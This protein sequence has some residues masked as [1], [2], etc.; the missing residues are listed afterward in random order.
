MPNPKNAIIAVTFRC[1]ARCT[2][3]DIWKHGPTDQLK[4]EYY[5][6]LPG[7]LREVNITGGEPLL[8]NDL[9]EIITNL[10]LINPKMRIVLSTNGLLPE[11]LSRLLEDHRD[12]V[13]RVS[14]DAIGEKHDIIRGVE[15]AYQKA[16]LSVEVAKKHGIKDIGICTTITRENADEAHKVQL[17]A[18]ALGVSFTA[19]VVHSSP[20][21]FGDQS[22]CKPDPLQT[23]DTLTKISNRFYASA[24]VK[25]WFKGY[26]V[27]G[28][29][30]LARGAPR[31]I[32]CHAGE[33]FFYLDPEGNIFP[34]HLWEKSIG[35][36]IEETYEEI[37]ARNPD[38]RQLVKRCPQKCW[39]TCTVAPEIRRSPLK[40]LLHVIGKKIRTMCVKTNED[41]AS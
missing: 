33:E 35:N 27:D 41:S 24:R 1:N 15:G 37:I 7:S 3:C 5:R 20:I 4:P 18:G 26:F 17:L 29:L 22:K 32:S 28:L 39:M 14:I 34:C 8:R 21:F 12:I 2:M 40:P 23:I 25:D 11:R 9:G 30:D 19:T 38:L 31:P 10:R 6:R 36:I 16:L 13:V